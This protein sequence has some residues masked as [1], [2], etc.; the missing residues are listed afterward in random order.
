MMGRNYHMRNAFLAALFLFL[1]CVQCLAQFIVDSPWDRNLSR[2]NVVE[3]DVRTES[4]EEA[5]QRFQNEYAVRS[6]LCCAPGHTWPKREFAFAGAS[7]TVKDFLDALCQ[8]YDGQWQ[9]DERTGV[10]WVFPKGVSY[11][12]LL[13]QEVR[14]ESDIH[15]MPMLDGVL[16][17][18]R[19]SQYRNPN[20]PEIEEAREAFY[21]QYR[22]SAAP[23][24][25][26]VAIAQGTY[27][28]RDILNLCAARMPGMTFY[29]GYDGLRMPIFPVPVTKDVFHF[30]M[31]DGIG[32]F[33]ARELGKA[34]VNLRDSECAAL[35]Y[36]EKM[37]SGTVRERWA[38]RYFCGAATLFPAMEAWFDASIPDESGIWAALGIIDLKVHVDFPPEDSRLPMPPSLDRYLRAY[39]TPARLSDGEARTVLLAGLEMY[40]A[41]FEAVPDEILSALHA[42]KFT[43][44]QLTG[45]EFELARIASYNEDIRKMLSD[46]ANPNY[47]DTG[48]FCDFLKREPKIHVVKSNTA[49]AP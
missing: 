47:I 38:A 27:S 25:Y 21:P 35:L 44:E 16:A 36:R 15:A 11:S 39:L 14:V 31:R 45:V 48:G 23:Y 49:P 10:I 46:P 32:D 30:N 28:M 33:A 42:R 6:I 37:A 1:S 26:A 5:W 3:I 12:S 13:P 18:C 4:V 34:N 2:L 9:H 17:K 40:R 29:I 19:A 41:S 22:G 43:P 24:N 7:A 20:H 8:T